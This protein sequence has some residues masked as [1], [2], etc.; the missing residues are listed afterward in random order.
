MTA[1]LCRLCRKEGESVQRITSGFENLVEK[2]HK[3]QHDNVAKKVQWYIC[4]KNG[5]EHSEKTN[6]HA[7]E[8]A[9]E[10]ED[11]KV[12]WNINIQCDKVI[13]SRLPD[14]IVIDKKEQ[15]RIISDIAVPAD[16]TVENDNN[17]NN[18]NNDNNHNNKE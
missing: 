11:I 12:L 9:V 1:P 8:G 13:K 7:P 4:K 18:N 14:L 15:K 6:E 16:V 17:N 3:R 2:D 5:L 10:Y